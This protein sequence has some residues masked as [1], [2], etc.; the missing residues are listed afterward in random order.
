[1]F[2]RGTVPNHQLDMGRPKICH[3][4]HQLKTNSLVE[5]PANSTS[6]RTAVVRE[7]CLLICDFAKKNEV[8][9][10]LVLNAGNGWVAGDCWDYGSFPHFLL[11]TSK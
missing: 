3:Q 4:R 11:S 7:K 5:D 6:Q 10:L 2:T 9:V 8:L 1:M